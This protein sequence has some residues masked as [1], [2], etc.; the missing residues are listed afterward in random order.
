M[1]ALLPASRRPN[2]LAG[3]RSVAGTGKNEPGD[4]EKVANHVVAKPINT[5]GRLAVALRPTFS[6][7]F[8]EVSSLLL[9]ARHG[10]GP[11]TG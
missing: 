4:T 10:M 5:R 1:L 8:D 7:V 11:P 9:A 3:D 2:T 6:I